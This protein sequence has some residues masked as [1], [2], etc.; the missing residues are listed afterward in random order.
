MKINKFSQFIKEDIDTDT[1]I[2][3]DSTTTLYRIVSVK[4][5]D[6][7]VVDTQNP[8]KYYFKSES[9]LDKTVL[10]HQG[11]EYHLIT[12]TTSSSNIDD[13]MSQQES[14]KNGCDCVVLKDDSKVEIESIIPFD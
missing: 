9:D 2:Q 3:N 5:G 8:G 12:V 7:L 11:D 1:I 6:P 10:D 4:D 13:E 14:E